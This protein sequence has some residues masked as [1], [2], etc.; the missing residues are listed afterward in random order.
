MGSEMCIRD[1]SL[2]EVTA[3]YVEMKPDAFKRVVLPRTSGIPTLYMEKAEIRNVAFQVYQVPESLAEAPADA[4]GAASAITNQG[5][6]EEDAAKPSR[7]PVLVN[8]TVD[9]SSASSSEAPSA[10]QSKTASPAKPPNPKGSS[11]KVPK[12]P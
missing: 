9:A 1:S 2:S 3:F 5:G 11:R 8:E 7:E 6:V 12:E 10:A 4:T